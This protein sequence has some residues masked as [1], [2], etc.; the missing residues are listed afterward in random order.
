MSKV[1]NI[2]HTLI[3]WRNCRIFIFFKISLCTRLDSLYQ[4]VF[5]TILCQQQFADTNRYWGFPTLL[6]LVEYLFAFVSLFPLYLTGIG[7][8]LPD[9]MSSSFLFTKLLLVEIILTTCL[10]ISCVGLE[11]SHIPSFQSVKICICICNLC[12]QQP[13]FY[14]KYPDTLGF[15]TS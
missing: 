5:S 3:L 13:C 4:L 11:V 9:N 12:Y 6:L 14:Y 1:D 7:G 15:G 8:N 2:F 10:A